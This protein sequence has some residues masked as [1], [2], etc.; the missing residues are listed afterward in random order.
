MGRSYSN[1]PSYIQISAMTEAN[2]VLPRRYIDSG[3]L[4][5]KKVI[6]DI[7]RIIDEDAIVSKLGR[8]RRDPNHVKTREISVV[9][10]S[11]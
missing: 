11:Q 3:K 4:Y 9:N 7:L 10:Q 1:S 5:V 6:L 2:L 8:R